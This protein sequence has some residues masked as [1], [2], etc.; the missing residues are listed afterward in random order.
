MFSSVRPSVPAR[1]CCFLLARPVHLLCVADRSW[2]S[3]DCVSVVT[4]AA[5]AVDVAEPV[6]VD[7]PADTDE[8]RAKRVHVPR[9]VLVVHGAPAVFMDQIKGIGAARFHVCNQPMQCVEVHV[10]DGP[11][12]YGSALPDG[13]CC[14]AL[15]AAAT[16]WEQWLMSRERTD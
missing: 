5:A 13:A 1:A 9:A 11:V 12:I 4:A 14:V 16:R 3:V 10:L 7:G 6:A 8:P 2:P 15:Q